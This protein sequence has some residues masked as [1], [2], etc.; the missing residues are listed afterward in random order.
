MGL[1]GLGNAASHASSNSS[2]QG[3]DNSASAFVTRP[4]SAPATNVGA[5]PAS[6]AETNL[7]AI[8]AAMKQG[9]ADGGKGNQRGS[10]F[11][12]AVALQN[13]DPS[14]IVSSLSNGPVP[15]GRPYSEPQFG[16]GKFV[17]LKVAS[18]SKPGQH[19]VSPGS[20][21]GSGKYCM[22][23]E[24]IISPTQARKLHLLC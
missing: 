24:K 9:G 6:E 20:S 12:G 15:G 11:S 21:N 23:Y 10:H 4:V 19:P 1:L 14:I 18:G 3:S 5:K 16:Q 17:E 22:F 7:Q 8:F 2:G 13:A